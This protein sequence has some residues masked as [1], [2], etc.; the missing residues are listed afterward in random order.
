MIAG[1]LSPGV[2]VTDIAVVLAKDTVE[3]FVDNN[4]S[5]FIILCNPV[6][7]RSSVIFIPRATVAALD[8]VFI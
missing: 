1:R 5:V 7:P 8:G 2:D 6:D 4:L 3:A